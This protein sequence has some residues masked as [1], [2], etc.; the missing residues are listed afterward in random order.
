M[1]RPHMQSRQLIRLSVALLGI[2]LLLSLI[3]RI[4][5]SAVVG[6]VKTVGWGL[7]LIIALGGISHLTK[8]LAWRLTFL[9]DVRNVSFARLFGLRLVS[10]AIGSFGLPGQVLGETM[11]VHL[12]GSALPVANSISSVTLDRGLY[13][14]TSALMSVTGIIA[15]LVLLSLSGNWRLYAFLFASAL[16]VLLVVTA[17]AFQRRWPVLSA[18]AHL[19]GSLPRF[20]NWVQGKQLIIDSA[21]SNLF[22]LYHEN[23]K[24]FWASL[25][26]NVAC[27]V[28][29]ILEVYVLLHFMG[30]RTGLLGAFVLEAF[31]KLINIVGAL[32]PGNF[33]TYE[34]GNMILT[35]LLGI[36]GAAGLTLGL[37]RRARSLFWKAMGFLCLVAMSRSTQQAR[38][39]LPVRYNAVEVS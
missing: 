20:K 30:S 6:Q 31:T 21:E 37:C 10:E 18:P 9:C 24:T 25:I 32:N 16:T 33:G 28:M 11:R 38:R 23:P 15:A 14:V 26:L 1:S 4:G 13:I 27:H 12:L 19:I 17:V 8:T 2:A 7:G 34:G 36:A 3:R 5:P 22:R 35:R 39:S 29:A